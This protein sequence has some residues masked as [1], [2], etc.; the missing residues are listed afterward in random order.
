MAAHS[1]PLLTGLDVSVL[2]P[3]ETYF[4]VLAPGLQNP[5]DPTWIKA[6]LARAQ[7]AGVDPAALYQEA[8]DLPRP[9]DWT[10]LPAYRVVSPE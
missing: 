10:P 3:Q 5:P 1:D 7:R 8:I 9:P 6:I 2:G 4:N